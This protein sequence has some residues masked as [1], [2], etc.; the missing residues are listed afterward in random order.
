MS[1][2]ESKSFKSHHA[3][4]LFQKNP[5]LGAEE[6]QDEQ[7]DDKQKPAG[8]GTIVDREDSLAKMSPLN[9]KSMSMQDIKHKG[10][11]RTGFSDMNVHSSYE[12]KL[13]KDKQKQTI[14]SDV[15]FSRKSATEE[16][17]DAE[18]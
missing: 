7:F 9:H 14:S 1:E 2:S 16:S 10:V 12:Q 4:S 8:F 13:S 3:N 15:Q 6:G 5:L 17:K 18:D 11:K